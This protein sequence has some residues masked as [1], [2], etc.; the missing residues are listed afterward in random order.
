[1]NEATPLNV[2]EPSVALP[3]GLCRRQKGETRE[4]GGHILDMFALGSLYKK[5]TPWGVLFVLLVGF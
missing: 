1:H 4:E 5:S 2:R 3:V